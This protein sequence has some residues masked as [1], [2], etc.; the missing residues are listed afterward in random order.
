MGRLL[1]QRY[2]AAEVLVTLPEEDSPCRILTQSISPL[3]YCSRQQAE[4]K[5]HTHNLVIHQ[6]RGNG[7]GDAVI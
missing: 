3:Y 1:S 6:H 2:T 7:L 4:H 5:I